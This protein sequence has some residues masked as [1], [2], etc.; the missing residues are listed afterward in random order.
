MSTLSNMTKEDWDA[1]FARSGG[2]D[3]CLCQE[4]HKPVISCGD[5]MPTWCE[6]CSKALDEK[7]GA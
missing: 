6:P 5:G 4:C 2:I 7:D 3:L 1:A